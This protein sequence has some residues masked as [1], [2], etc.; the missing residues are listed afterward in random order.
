M[1]TKSA[2]QTTQRDNHRFDVHGCWDRSKAGDSC[3]FE[4][5]TKIEGKP[6]VYRTS[7]SIASP[8]VTLPSYFPKKSPLNE[9]RHFDAGNYYEISNNIFSIK[10][11]RQRA[12]RFRGTPY[13]GSKIINNAFSHG[14]LLAKYTAPSERKKNFNSAIELQWHYDDQI[15]DVDGFKLSP[16]FPSEAVYLDTVNATVSN[17]KLGY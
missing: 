14:E 7:D 3:R 2:R 8:K 13:Y 12:I 5:T 6:P 9:V 15:A 16:H 4:R 10:S 11:T 17:N 1:K